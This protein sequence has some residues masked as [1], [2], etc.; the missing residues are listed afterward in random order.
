MGRKIL[1]VTTDQQRF[2]ALGC[3][4]GL[5]AR[6]P[7]ADRLAAEGINYTRAVN[8]NVVCMP[9]RSTM[10]TGQYPRTHGVYANG[11]PL[12]A[13]APSIA[14]YLN[15]HGYRTGLFGKA[16]FEP[17]MDL[18]G[19]WPENR[20][21]REGTYGPHRGFERLELA[22]HGPLPLWHYG[23][24]IRQQPGQHEKDFY[25]LF[26]GGGL[27]GSG[28]GD[29]GA[30]QVK[31][32]PVPRDLYHTDWVADRTISWLE[33]L[34]SDDDWFCWMS[35]PDPHH[36]WD[37]P[38]SELKRVP[39]RDLDLPDGH[40][41]SPEE[42]RRILAQKPRHWLAY[43]DGSHSNLEG[44]PAD[45]VPAN[46]THDQVREINAFTHVEN[47]LI[48]EALG[49]VLSAIERRGWTGD[50]DVIFTTD[51]GELQGD[52]GLLFKGPYHCDALMR[53]PMIWRPAPSAGV[54][55]AVVTDPVG[56]LDLAPTFAG[57]A[58]LP[59]PEW[60]EGAPLPTGDGQ[61][62]ERVICEW[63]SQFETEDLHLS[64]LYR[65]G[66][67]V[68]EYGPGGGYDGSEG[69]LYNL[70]D[71]PHQWENRWDDPATKALREDL[72]ADLHDHLPPP[73]QPRLAVEA[74]V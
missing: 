22:M 35:F 14:A 23:V 37:P 50:T 63:E 52:F 42:C 2:D 39:W 30:C 59:V 70:A 16:H 45:F 38:A 17:G 25:Q 6:T 61:G 55:P 10:I 67:V 26:D 33:S 41:G 34:D 65:D 48:D 66:W 71:D 74:P 5:I 62:R 51:H 60:V 3:N 56:Q 44:G 68:T 47:E 1:F 40:P 49:R 64:T 58:G 69:E 18:E 54:A 24:W 4:G 32:N 12:P 43:Y 53:L 11:V 28:G 7:V 15:D 36:P 8:Q 72:L 21:A 27:N 29:T 20:F 73:R 9:A 31:V 57:I 46:M 19:R 13:D